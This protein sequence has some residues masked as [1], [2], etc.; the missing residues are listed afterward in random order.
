M[1]AG[2]VYLKDEGQLMA[3]DPPELPGRESKNSRV[4]LGFLGMIA[5][6]VCAEAS[7]MAHDFDFTTLVASNWRS[8]G[9]TPS[10]VAASNEILCFGDSML[11]FGLQP[12]ILSDR[13]GKSSY[14][15]ALYCGSAASSY[16][17]LKRSFDAGARPV[18]VVVD[19]Q[20]ELLMCDSMSVLS[21]VY[22]ELLT[23]P[24]IV[25][26]CWKARD[27]DRLAEFFVAKVL[28][29]ARKRY[30][31]R[32]SVMAAIKGQSVSVKEKLL[33]ARRNWK[34][35][36][37]AEVLPPNPYYQ[38]DVPETGAYPAMFWTPW[39]VTQP[40]AQ[41]V[42]GF[43]ELAASHNVPVFWVLQPN[44]AVVDQRREQVGYNAQ[45]ESYVRAC[46]AKFSNLVVIDGRHVNYPHQIFTDPVHLDR[47]GAVAF[48][49]GVAEILRAHLIEHRREPRWVALPDHRGEVAAY[50]LEDNAESGLALQAEKATTR[51]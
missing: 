48:S 12:R 29:S 25:E 18:A 22:P 2:S 49:L 34:V 3:S 11:K 24:E 39:F 40:S 7:I 15:M 46:Q 10:K 33:A 26:L 43:L 8:E 42:P 45:Y 28:A 50:S 32:A 16:Y 30:E 27:A 14:N 13:V 6:V 38:G 36:R 4:P 41:Y 35:N 1:E 5:L 31:I 23:F 37:G 51:R 20:P 19:F 9:R 47:N 17:M 21:R 44:A